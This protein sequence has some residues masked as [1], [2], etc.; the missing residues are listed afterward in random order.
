M[1]RKGTNAKSR[2]ATRGPRRPPNTAT[3]AINK[4]EWIRS[5]PTTMHAKDVVEKAKTAGIKLS[6]AQ[7]Y[8][9]RSLAKRASK[10]SGASAGQDPV[11]PNISTAKRSRSAAAGGDE[12]AFRRLALS[13][14]L[15]RAESY[16]A[17]LR[18][19]TGL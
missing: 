12:L 15:T 5:Q 8:T 11:Q 17:A 18:R 7:V 10:E 13:I 16:L 6:V 14:G 1:P 9:T 4:A 2:S 19:N 3:K